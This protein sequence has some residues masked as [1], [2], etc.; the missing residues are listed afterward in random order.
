MKDMR[1]LVLILI[2]FI[3]IGVAAFRVFT[4]STATTEAEYVVFP[5]ETVIENADIV[6]AG[7]VVDIGRVRWNQEN[8]RFWD[9]DHATMFHLVTIQADEVFAG[10]IKPGNNFEI[11]IFGGDHTNENGMGI[12]DGVLEGEIANLDESLQLNERV[13]IFAEYDEL[14]WSKSGGV[15][16]STYPVIAPIGGPSQ[17]IMRLSDDGVFVSENMPAMTLENVQEAVK[18][19]KQ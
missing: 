13:L 9:G 10:D 6:V 14:Q 5:Y 12:I 4:F 15:S 3:A 11:I 17:G 18:S 2:G 1:H 8:G 16:D 19:M 7:R